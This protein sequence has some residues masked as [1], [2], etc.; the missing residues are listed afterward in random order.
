MSKDL[1]VSEITTVND[2][3]LTRFRYETMQPARS[4]NISSKCSIAKKASEI[5]GD[6]ISIREELRFFSNIVPN[7]MLT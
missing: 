4:T 5:N 3:V 7:M 2:L 1:T 6:A